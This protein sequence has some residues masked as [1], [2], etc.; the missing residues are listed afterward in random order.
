MAS[1]NTNTSYAI[2]PLLEKLSSEDSDY[3]F[4]SLSDL[5]SILSNKAV[6][7]ANDS[8]TT[9]NRIVDGV[10]KSLSDNNA[11]VQNLAVK[12][13]APLTAR[14]NDTQLTN[15]LNR[16]SSFSIT[17]TD[18]SLGSTALRTIITNV[19]ATNAVGKIFVGRLLH[20]LLPNLR[21]STDSVDVLVDL[22]NRFGSSLTCEQVGE[23][24]N[25]L[26]GVLET[27]KGLVRKR[28]VGALGALSNHLTPQLWDNMMTYL[29]D[30]FNQGVPR[31]RLRILVSV[32]GTLCKANSVRLSPYLLQLTGSVLKS[33]DVEDDDVRESALITLDTFV[34]SCPVEMAAFTGD[35][36]T[37]GSRFIK[38]DPNYAAV[39]EDDEEMEDAD[40]EQNDDS[41]L[42][43]EFD[44]E[45]A[46]SDEDDVSWRLRRCAAKLLDTLIETRPDLL[47]Q[48]YTSIAPLLVSRFKEREETV[49][50]EVLNTFATLIRQTASTTAAAAAANTSRRKRRMSDDSMILESDPRR[51]LPDLSGRVFKL[52]SQHLLKMSSLPSKQASLTV[53]TETVAVLSSLPDEFSLFIPTIEPAMSQGTLRTSIINFVSILVTN[54]S[55]EQLAEYLHTIVSVVVAGADD[56]FYKISS[57]ALAAAGDVIVLITTP[58]NVDTSKYIARL[59]ET[60]VAKATASEADLEVRERAIMAIGQLLIYA[61]STL[62]KKEKDA[63]ADIL[64]ER[65]KNETTRPATIRSIE[66]IAASPSTDASV[67]VNKWVNEV[68][69]ELAG[70]LRKSNRAIRASALSALKVMTEKFA[71][72]ID[73]ATAAGMVS[74]LRGVIVEDD[75]QFLGPALSVL[76]T[77]VTTLGPL[78]GDIT[79][80]VVDLVPK[81]TTPITTEPLLDLLSAFARAG[82]AA[83]LVSALSN[84]DILITPTGAKALAVVIVR[85]GLVDDR[86]AQIKAE[87]GRTDNDSAAR[88][89]LMVLGEIA[90]LLGGELPKDLLSHEFLFQ[91]FSA[92]SSEVRVAAAQTLGAIAASNVDTYVPVIISQLTPE[93]SNAKMLVVALKEAI[94]LNSS[95]KARALSLAPYTADLWTQLFALDLDASSRTTGGEKGSVKAIAAE[96]IARLTTLDP[97]KF[98]TE[99]QTLLRSSDVGTRSIIISAVRFLFSQ[100]DASVA[101]ADEASTDELLRP[102]VIDFLALLEDPDLENRRLAISAIASVAHNKPNIL[103]DHLSRVLGLLFQDTFIRPELIR[104]VQMG[105]FKHKVDDGVDV[106]K[107]AYDSLYAVLVAFAQLRKADL[108]LDVM[109]ERAIAGLD[110][111]H[112]VKVTSCVI[113]GKIAETDAS[114]V[115]TKLDMLAKKFTDVLSLKLKE[116]AIKQEVEKHGE[117]QRRAIRTSQQIQAAFATA[118]KSAD[119]ASASTEMSPAWAKYLT[120]TLRTKSAISQ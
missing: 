56:K 42:D 69:I 96:C 73:G 101:L 109:T 2:Q 43:N 51:Q 15:V 41:E 10:L 44:D 92:A 55:L 1:Y 5:H 89:A 113:L 27:G 80:T 72:Q 14:I 88:S 6:A 84:E 37:V 3:R 119:A 7:L 9:I 117:L 50:V 65:L 29:I 47:S 32:C 45:D 35:I 112:D 53:A 8:T 58:S 107:A 49:R 108:Q 19:P 114:V 24:Q 67:F 34:G 102:V 76:T 57:E 66:N 46:F 40:D 81:L 16:L 75:L 23:T 116:T 95:S 71:P 111:D 60:V 79:D 82:K 115:A 70:L 21:N 39:D 74:V 13:L 110:D 22:V 78:P 4:M 103:A 91:Q 90:K 64:L 83:S 105:P 30:S 68:V 99:L 98:I 54:H 62:S 94:V 11:E 77:L 59:H 120:E 26:I 97:S 17:D 25:A 28:A 52:L 85:G 48:L 33:L 20:T 61:R 12:C 93:S 106:R 36:I 118:E 86:V 38:Y 100:N 87:A 31:D 104:E 63:D 18:G